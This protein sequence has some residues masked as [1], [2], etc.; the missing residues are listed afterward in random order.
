MALTCPVDFD[1]QRLQKEVMNIYGRVATE[2][3][4][5]FHFHR[6]PQYAAEF[7]S[8]DPPELARLPVQVTASFAGIGNPH[9]IG[10]IRPVKPLW[11]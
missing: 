4:G 2:P 6:G 7:L 3:G 9:R 5:E 10:P 11:I 8:Y 1:T